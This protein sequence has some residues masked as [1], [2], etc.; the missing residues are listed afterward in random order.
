MDISTGRIYVSRHVVFNESVFPFKPVSPITSSTSDLSSCAEIGVFERWVDIPTSTSSTSSSHSPSF[1][2]SPHPPSSTLSSHS[3]SFTSSSHPPS[4]TSLFFPF[5]SSANVQTVTDDVHTVDGVS[6]IVPSGINNVASI[7]DHIVSVT[8]P[9]V[10]VTSQVTSM[11]DQETYTSNQVLS[12]I[13]QVV[14]VAEVVSQNDKHLGSVPNTATVHDVNDDTSP[15]VPDLTQRL[16]TSLSP[17]LT[18]RPTEITDRVAENLAANSHSM[19]TRSKVGVRKPNPKYALIMNQV[20]SEPLTVKEALAHPAVGR[21]TKPLA[22]KPL[23]ETCV[24]LGLWALPQPSLRRD[25][26]DNSPGP[27]EAQSTI[28]S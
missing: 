24:K 13:D 7:S 19:M 3:P 6:K 17:G 12:E 28:N 25:I 4:S 20:P 27:I 21:H 15:L 11:T 26:K 10:P 8:T 9:L 5:S 2:S 22:Y 23:M 16:D 1:T 14:S 18:Q